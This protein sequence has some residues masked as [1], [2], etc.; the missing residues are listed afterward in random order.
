MP[1]DDLEPRVRPMSGFALGSLLDPLSI[2]DL[3]ALITELDREKMRIG[4]ELERRHAQ[5]SAAESLF[6][7]KSAG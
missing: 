2:S 6:R 4:E 5:A 7:P 3:E 1:S